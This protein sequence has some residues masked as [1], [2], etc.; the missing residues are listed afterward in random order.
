MTSFN[1]HKHVA[2]SNKTQWLLT[3]VVFQKLTSA[4][5]ASAH[6]ALKQQSSTVLS[7]STSGSQKDDAED[8][9]QRESVSG[10]G[11]FVHAKA[12]SIRLRDPTSK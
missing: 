4:P 6:T 1:I 8:V 2:V 3:P 10:V 7:T 5:D 12:K 11:A 9:S